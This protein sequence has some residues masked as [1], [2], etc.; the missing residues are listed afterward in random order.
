MAE[1]KT[2]TDK[3][4]RENFVKYCNIRLRNAIKSIELL[5]NLSNK[6]AYSYTKDDV[7]KIKKALNDAIR[8]M[9]TS[10]MNRNKSI[11]ERYI[12]E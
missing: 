4:K 10:F 11:I 2:L 12:I 7:A 3:E 9:D 6:R 5:G 1:T 8:T